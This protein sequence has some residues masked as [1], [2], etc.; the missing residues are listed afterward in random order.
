MKVYNFG[1]ERVPIG[2]IT[3]MVF[4][5]SPSAPVEKTRRILSYFIR[6][7]TL[8]IPPPAETP[9]SSSSSSPSSSTLVHPSTPP[10][11]FAPPAEASSSEKGKEPADSA[12]GGGESPAPQVPSLPPKVTATEVP[13]M[14]VFDLPAKGPRK[15]DIK[16]TYAT[17]GMD[18][19]TGEVSVSPSSFLFF[20][21]LRSG[22]C[23]LTVILL[24]ITS[25]SSS[26]TDDLVSPE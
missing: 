4:V 22:S 16:N 15:T 1:Q 21:L 20:S 3:R 6:R 10:F 19:A 9:S 7:F 5:T 2:L 8:V 23:L 24:S 25:C 18:A 12:E 13:P 26:L 14:E 17:V 11:S